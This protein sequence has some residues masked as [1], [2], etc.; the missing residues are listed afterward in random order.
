MAWLELLTIV[1]EIAVCEPD[2]EPECAPKYG[3]FVVFVSSFVD[4]RFVLF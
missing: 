1:T 3:F 4:V 2:G